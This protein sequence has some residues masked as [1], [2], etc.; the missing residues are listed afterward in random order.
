MNNLNT[1]NSVIRDLIKYFQINHKTVFRVPWIKGHEG[2]TENDLIDGLTVA[3]HKRLLPHKDVSILVSFIRGG[4]TVT[5]DEVKL[6]S[7]GLR[8][9]EKGG[10]CLSSKGAVT[11]LPF[12]NR[13][14]KIDLGS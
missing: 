9:H 5:R 14:R 1:R 11:S 7:M 6:A 4:R 13:N 12:F 2:L 10:L 8:N 3:A